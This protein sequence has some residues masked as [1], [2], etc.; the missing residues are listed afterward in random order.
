MHC[1]CLGVTA[2]TLVDL[3]AQLYRTQEELRL[4]GEA[5]DR[6]K[7]RATRRKA[8]I[9]L[10]TKNRGVEERDLKDK[11]QVKVSELVVLFLS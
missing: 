2:S 11:L 9:D 4:G 1:C 5:G 6:V 3:K 10:G 8:G 7:A